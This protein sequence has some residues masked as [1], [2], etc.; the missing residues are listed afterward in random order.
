MAGN[1]WNRQPRD[2]WSRRKRATLKK[3][4][5]ALAACVAV[6]GFGA[7]RASAD[8]ITWGVNDDAGKYEKGVG[9]FWTT[10]KGVG[11]TSNTITLRW[12]ETSASGF[13]GN[14]A[15][16]VAPSL[17]AAKAANVSITFDVYPRHSAALAD[18]ANAARFAAWVAK[19]AQTYPDVKEYVVMNECNTSLFANPQYAGGQNVSA[20]QCD[21][22]LA[23]A[24]DAL[25][26]VSSGIFVWGLGLSPRGNPVPT[27]GS[28]P[29][30]T[31]PV[32][33][34]KFLGQW[35]RRSGRSAPLMDGLDIHPYPIP[36]NLP[37]E[38][39]Y[40]DPTSYSVT[41]LPRVY[42]AF[43]TA[44]AGTSQKTVGPGRLPVSLNEVGIQTIPTAAVAGSYTGAENAEGIS[45]SGTEAYQA[46][47]YSKLVDFAL[48]DA[49]ITK[50]NIFKLVDESGL[51]GWQ[52]GLFYQGYVAKASA[53]AFAAEVG[54]TAGRCPSGSASYFSPSS[55]PVTTK[56]VTKGKPVK[57]PVTKVTKPA[58]KP[59]KQTVKHAP[60]TKG[61]KK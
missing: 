18:P 21:A 3:V 30:A 58:K 17:A 45:S 31:N 50:V 44:F 19:L 29:R 33:W 40:A 26:S 12:D 20:A 39:G 2:T 48:C 25:K 52:S 6:V 1:G 41:N 28:S 16:F 15:D 53:G 7:A 60:P 55:A 43:Y 27:D 57:K 34:L 49:D 24:Y 22:F 8:N 38:T 42:A 10:L 35:Y 59:V 11:M 56:P 14:E 5:A 4:L 54:K 32:D 13:D 47:W 9:S 37:F 23:A 36:Q 51:E 61:K 46:A